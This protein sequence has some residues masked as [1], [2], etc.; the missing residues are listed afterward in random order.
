MSSKPVSRNI[1]LDTT[2]AKKALSDLTE[3]QRILTSKITEGEKAGKSM[4]SEIAKLDE[5][6]SKI[7]SVQDVLDKGLAPSLREQEKLVKQLR[8]ELRMMS[9]DT[10]GFTQK[11]SAYKNASKDLDGLRS[12]LQGVNSSNN[13]LAT[14]F[15]GMAKNILGV[16][17]AAELAKGALEFL[18]GSVSEAQEAEEA[19]GRFSNTLDNIG[20]NDA[21]ERLMAKADEM[22]KRFKYIDNDDVIGVFEKLITYG[23]LTERQINDLTP[24]IINF[25][26]KQKIS[27]SE[28]SSVV[29]K[30]LEGNAKALK[31]YGINVKEGSDVTE[32]MGILMNELAPKV[33]GAADAFG[34][35]FKGQLEIARQEIRDTQEEIGQGLL[36]ILAK[37]MKYTSIAVKGLVEMGG[38][39]KKVF[40][41]GS[42]EG[43]LKLSREE[44]IAKANQEA[45]EK[46]TKGL[47]EAYRKDKSGKDRSNKEIIELIQK[48][49]E[50]DQKQLAIAI[51]FGDAKRMMTYEKLVADNKRAIE[52]LQKEMNTDLDKVLGLGGTDNS[53]DDKTAKEREALKARF[54]ELVA[55]LNQVALKF[56]LSPMELEF[57]KINDVLDKQIKEIEKMLAKGAINAKQAAD[58]IKLA[59]LAALVNS[60]EAY[61]KDQKASDKRFAD[62]GIILPER[63]R[64]TGSTRLQPPGGVARMIREDQ[65]AGLRNKVND[66]GNWKAMRDAQLKLLAEEQADVLAATQATGEKRLEILNEFARRAAEIEDQYKE[67]VVGLIN[68]IGGYVNQALSIMASFSQARTNIENNAFRREQQNNEKRK[69]DLESTRRRGLITENEY[70]IRIAKMDEELDTKRRKLEAQQFERNRKQ[71]VAQAL[72]NGAL[73]ITAAW[74]KPGFPLALLYTALI[75]ANTAAQ[76][77]VINS[78]KPQFRHGGI[79]DGPSH[80][81]R[82]GQSGIALVRRDNGQEVGEMEGGEPYMILSRKF[83]QNN[84]G[85]IP[86]LL[87]ASRT[88]QTLFPTLLNRPYNMSLNYDAFSGRRSFQDGGIVSDRSAN[89]SP[90]IVNQDI[91]RMQL[92]YDQLAELFSRPI[93]AIVSQ[94]QID[95]NDSIRSKIQK[96]ATLR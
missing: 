91:E 17:T 15:M 70:R 35:T 10:P 48:A 64:S 29:I 89:T 53:E 57:M 11:L 26:A 87:N 79:P 25:A 6:K 51:A 52:S 67:K 80:G 8:A 14:S 49:D 34:K 90:I 83:R 88:G 41:T 39:L 82:Y 95:D 96:E 7:K 45:E 69:K 73:G 32:R 50:F 36:P 60:D 27:L 94:K 63:I 2:S 20:R 56:D 77:G 93:T 1:Y 9:Q 46:R 12:K 78:Q 31:E 28:S 43:A 44:L 58:A 5:V 38:F 92:I 76:I 37:L 75:A 74:V 13:S 71:Q 23:K 72:I 61:Y 19:L 3:Q 68:E 55:M 86:M 24:V 18:K 81:S 85:L 4:V 40:E 62:A 47:I 66:A 22:Q 30:A 84:P 54:E 59:K 21:L 65:M 33:D 42:V 16:V